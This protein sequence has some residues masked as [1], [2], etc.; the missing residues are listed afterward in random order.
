[1]A[2]SSI[3]VGPGRAG[4][5]V[6]TA[7]AFQSETTSAKARLAQLRH[8][9]TIR[10]VST[11]NLFIVDFLCICDLLFGQQEPSKSKFGPSVGLA[12][13]ASTPVSSGFKP[14]SSD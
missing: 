12:T 9:H 14:E 10:H 13:D 5:V 6:C 11:N 7:I 8:M 4:I 3:A 1:M 2:K